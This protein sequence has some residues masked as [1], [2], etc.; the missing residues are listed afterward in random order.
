MDL[1]LPTH[2]DRVLTYLAEAESFSVFRQRLQSYQTADFLYHVLFPQSDPKPL[3]AALWRG[4]VRA[5]QRFPLRLGGELSLALLWADFLGSLRQVGDIADAEW[6]QARTDLVHTQILHFGETGWLAGLVLTS[7]YD[8]DLPRY[9]A[10]SIVWTSP[11]LRAHTLTW[12]TSIWMAQGTWN[13]IQK[14]N[15][16]FLYDCL[17]RH[18][19]ETHHFL[20]QA[21]FMDA[22][23][24]SD[25]DKY[26]GIRRAFVRWADNRGLVSRATLEPKPR[27]S[28]SEVKIGIVAANWHER[29]ASRK[30]LLT[31]VQALRAWGAQVYLVDTHP[32]PR[33]CYADFDG[34]IP[35][36]LTATPQGTVIE[37]SELA[38]AGLDFL[39]FIETYQAEL[40]S[41]LALRRYAPIQ[42]TG[43]GIPI[44]TQSP[45]I[46]YFFTGSLV[47]SRRGLRDYRETPL[48]LPGIGMH[49]TPRPGVAPYAKAPG[50]IRVVVSAN[51]IKFTSDYL[52]TL[53]RIAKAIP[54]I[55]WVFLPNNFHPYSL[56]AIREVERRFQPEKVSW[57]L[58]TQKVYLPLLQSADLILDAVPYSGYTTVVDAISLGV[59]ILTWRGVHGHER[60]GSAVAELGGMP[61]WLTPTSLPAFEKRAIQLL[62]N[63]ALRFL[64]HKRIL[65]HRYRLFDESQSLAFADAVKILLKTT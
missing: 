47:E 43:Y 60:L 14:Q 34:T 13:P 20:P 56:A 58:H 50:Q 17:T 52:D 18:A 48:I 41:L 16:Q 39:Y 1:R 12:M 32:H 29:H 55:D 15:R 7:L 65:H 42:A 31:S 36:R 30:A 28:S 54:G 26:A 6:R 5:L 24:T 2:P 37:D 19:E 51:L 3:A 23:W 9:V 21:A 63:P 4:S 62:R 49:S 33:T 38:A 11:V 57:Y 10:S 45:A 64:C 59:P 25:P 61:R 22:Y 27:T 53:A 40:D 46:D 44:S 8:P 35:V